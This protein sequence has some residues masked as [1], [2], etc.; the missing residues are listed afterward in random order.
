M[1]ILITCDQAR[2]FSTFPVVID[3]VGTFLSYPP[4]SIEVYLFLVRNW[5]E[6]AVKEMKEFHELDSKK[7]DEII[8]YLK[9]IESGEITFEQFVK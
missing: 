3:T 4:Q 7:Q 9:I 8:S 6:D 1:L 2:Y 5:S